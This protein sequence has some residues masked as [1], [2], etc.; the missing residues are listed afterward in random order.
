MVC[1]M[2]RRSPLL[3][4][5]A[6]GLLLAPLAAC[7][8]GSS[9]SGG[10]PG[11]GMQ[12]DSSQDAAP[13]EGTDEAPQ[14]EQS[15]IQTG[16]ISIEVPD[17]AEA[18]DEV[19]EVAKDLDGR[20]E[21]QSVSGSGDDG[22]RNAQLTLRVPADRF[23]DAFDALA[24]IGT[25]TTQERSATDVTTEHVD[26]QARVEA[27]EASVDRLTEL[28]SSSGSTGELIEAEAA[29]SERQQELD[30]LRAQLEALEDQVDLATVQVS[31]DARSALPGGP[32]NFWEGLVAGFDSL[33]STGSGSLVVIGILLPWL[34]LAGVIALIIV[35]IVRSARRRRRIG[36]A[37]APTAPP[38]PAAGPDP[39]PADPAGTVTTDPAGTAAGDATGAPEAAPGPTSEPPRAG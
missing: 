7:A 10:G 33:V 16:S 5:I 1:T 14:A 34:V 24:A 25:V 23:D 26:L 3:A 36:A 28:M 8:P 29:L 21:S 27:L 22:A 18:A 35:L 38:A 2:R 20:V 19:S 13:A 6:A 32:S 9:G 30:G 37:P 15:V 12:A 11:S 31:L 39:E 4:I 17:P